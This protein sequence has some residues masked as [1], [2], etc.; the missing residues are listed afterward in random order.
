MF[1]PAK[2]IV[3]KLVQCSVLV[4]ATMGA[5]GCASSAQL[6]VSAGTGPRP[7]CLPPT[8]R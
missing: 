3:F 8:R 6:P 4:A 1:Q 5:V 7:T 2:K